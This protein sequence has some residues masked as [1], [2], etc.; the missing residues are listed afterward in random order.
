MSRSARFRTAFAVFLSALL[1]SS[2]VAV[3]GN[4]QAKLLANFWE[5]TY[6]FSDGETVGDCLDFSSSGFANDFDLTSSNFGNF[7]CA[8]DATG[9]FNS[10]KFD[11]S[12]SAFE[13]VNTGGSGFQYN[14]KLKSKKL[15]GQ[16]ID[17]LG[18]S[19]VFECTK[20]SSACP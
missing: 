16:V 4:C 13:C 11:S 20:R 3:A 19:G 1:G 12:G 7:V 8:C 17:A 9:S 15:G 18:L 2:T 6:N 14:G 10:P 5:C